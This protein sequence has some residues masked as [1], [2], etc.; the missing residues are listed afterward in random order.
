MS[1]RQSFTRTRETSKLSNFIVGALSRGDKI[2]L[3]HIPIPNGLGEKATLIDISISNGGLMMIPAAPNQWDKVIVFT[4]KKLCIHYWPVVCTVCSPATFTFFFMK[5]FALLN[6]LGLKTQWG[7][8]FAKSSYFYLSKGKVL[9]ISLWLKQQEITIQ[10]KLEQNTGMINTM[11]HNYLHKFS[12][13]P[14]RHNMAR[15]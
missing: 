4:H 2:V 6:G 1:E 3:K 11:S 9:V 7:S 5:L 10:L 15:C 8:F 14:W 12:E 13:T